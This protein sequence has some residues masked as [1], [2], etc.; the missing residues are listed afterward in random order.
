MT[1]SPASMFPLHNASASAVGGVAASTGPKKRLF[2]RAPTARASR[3]SRDHQVKLGLMDMYIH[4]YHAVLFCFLSILL[5]L[6][7]HSLLLSTISF[8]LFS[9][10]RLI[11]SS[12][13]TFGAFQRGKHALVSIVDLVGA[14]LVK[15][16][17]RPMGTR[18][19][20]PPA[21]KVLQHL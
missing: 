10:L 16:L 9:L 7:L 12:I 18:M 5:L 4:V 6:L 17:L 2:K 3:S 19:P 13:R 20:P 11:L 15:T 14:C 8:V 21:P 1:T